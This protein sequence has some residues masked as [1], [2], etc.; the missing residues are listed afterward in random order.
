MNENDINAKRVKGKLKKD[1]SITSNT[2]IPETEP[3]DIQLE[4]VVARAGKKKRPAPTVDL[5]AAYENP[6]YDNAEH[7]GISEASDSD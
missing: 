4:E 7:D 3:E 2:S 5:D 1:D 6:V